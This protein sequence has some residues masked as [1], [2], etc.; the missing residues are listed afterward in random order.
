MRLG[1]LAQDKVVVSVCLAVLLCYGAETPTSRCKINSRVIPSLLCVQI[2]EGA[3][4]RIRIERSKRRKFV[5]SVRDA[6]RFN[7]AEYGNTVKKAFEEIVKALRA[8]GY[9]GDITFLQ[10]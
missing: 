6:G 7:G 3:M 2:L 10:G 9:K 8:R 5:A 4:I 1:T